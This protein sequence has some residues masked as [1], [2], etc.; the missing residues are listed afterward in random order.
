MLMGDFLFLISVSFFSFL[1]N[2]FAGV[3]I[4]LFLNAVGLAP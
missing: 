1:I 3:P 4:N 2:T